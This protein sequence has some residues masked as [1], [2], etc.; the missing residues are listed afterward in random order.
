M[1]MSY[2]G[3]P[4]DMKDYR[5][6][7]TKED[8]FDCF[9]EK[10]IK[11]VND[12]PLFYQVNETD[13][14]YSEI[15]VYQLTFNGLDGTPIYGWYIKNM[16][17][18]NSRCLL[19]THGYR[20]H[21]NVPHVYLHWL[22]I[23]CDVIALDMRLQGGETGCL[24]NHKITD[25]VITLN[26][27]NIEQSYL[28]LI[29]SD[30]MLATKVIEKLGY[31]EYILEGTSQAGGLAVA[32]GCLLNTASMVLANVPSNS[33]IEKRIDERT[34]AFKAFNEIKG[35]SM[36]KIKRNLSYFDTK[37]MADRLSIPLFASVGGED[38]VC[39]MK[40]FAATYN[41]IQSD[42]LIVVYPHAKHEGGGANQVEKE[43]AVVQ[44]RDLEG[45]L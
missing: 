28:Y 21:R 25:E 29:Y 39:P 44:K 19:T 43:L 18:K 17:S 16:N 35:I 33:D 41:R 5:G 42:K 14:F 7:L 45:F 2:L 31:E 36:E 22:S 8:D 1:E 15:K 38:D 12:L 37:N 30:M 9:W 11:R 32:I 10:T 20:S 26:I 27:E 24:T 23:G 6:E 34:G 3:L 40:S 4:D 13:Y